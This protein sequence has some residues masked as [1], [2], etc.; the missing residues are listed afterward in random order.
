MFE[1]RVTLWQA[2]SE[3]D[4]ISQ[5]QR[6]AA[7]YVAT[8]NGRRSSICSSRRPGFLSLRLRAAGSSLIRKSSL[9]P[10]E[11]LNAFF[12]TGNENQRTG[13]WRLPPWPRHGSGMF[14]EPPPGSDRSVH[15]CNEHNG[16]D[17]RRGYENHADYPERIV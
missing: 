4:A 3:D 5:A 13:P 8:I 7:E 6:E 12:D 9:T 16:S 10:A 14:S 15:D 17:S 2:P 11:Y 1:E